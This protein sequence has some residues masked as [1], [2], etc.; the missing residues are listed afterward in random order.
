MLIAIATP[1]QLG[2]IERMFMSSGEF[3]LRLGCA[4]ICGAV[5]GTERQWRRRTTGLRTDTLFVVGSALFVMQLL[6]P[7]RTD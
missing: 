1:A 4:L 6:P 5:I 3:A 2:Y 7:A